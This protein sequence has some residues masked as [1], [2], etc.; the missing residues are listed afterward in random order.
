MSAY[1]YKQT[2][3]EVRQRVRFTPESGHRCG[4]ISTATI[5]CRFD[6]PDANG[7][8]QTAI[9]DRDQKHAMPPEGSTKSLGPWGQS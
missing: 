7:P 2:C 4:E 1:G 6:K 9:H 3:G 8:A 5:G